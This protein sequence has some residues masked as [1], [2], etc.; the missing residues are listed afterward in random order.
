MQF[1]IRKAMPHDAGALAS[2]Q[3]ASW[4]SAFRNIA[5]DS[6]L[7]NAANEKNQIEE[8]QKILDE[9]SQITLVAEVN[10]HLI[11]YVL[12]SDETSEIRQWDSE[13]SSLHVLPSYKRLGVGKSLVSAAA[14][15]LKQRGCLSVYLWVLMDNHPAVAFYETLM[16][17]RAESRTI[18]FAGNQVQECIYYWNAIDDLIMK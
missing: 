14:F 12:A 3:V 1:S 17:T 4:R 5:P 2:V 9:K 18:D 7:D 11:A 13:I 10:N 15:E 8:W 16:G 6:Y